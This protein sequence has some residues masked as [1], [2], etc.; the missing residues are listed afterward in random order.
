MPREPQLPAA[1]PPRPSPC[2]GLARLGQRDSLSQRAPEAEAQQ[3]QQQQQTW[4]RCLLAPQV[5][6]CMMAPPTG[7]AVEL[8]GAVA[9]SVA[10]A[11]P[12]KLRGAPASQHGARPGW[13]RGLR[14]GGLQGRG[15]PSRLSQARVCCHAEASVIHTSLEKA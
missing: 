12:A 10:Q 15:S 5:S 6:P 8:S 3:Q 4:L 1:A 9:V 14:A 2:K 11:G 13:H 7:G